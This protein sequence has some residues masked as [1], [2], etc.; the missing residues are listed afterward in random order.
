MGTNSVV[1]KPGEKARVCGPAMRSS[2]RSYLVPNRL[3][4]YLSETTSMAWRAKLFSVLR[5]LAM[6]MQVVEKHW[7]AT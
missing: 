4:R 3:T 2:E 7:S 5:K 1:I 6:L